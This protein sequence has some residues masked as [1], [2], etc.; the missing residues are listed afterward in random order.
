MADP[1]VNNDSKSDVATYDILVDG[2]VM[3]PSFQLLSLSVMKESNRIPVAKLIFRDGEAAEKEFSLS[4]DAAFV[5]G[6]KIVIKIG[7]DTTNVQ[8]FAGIIIMHAV[9]IKSNGNS[10]LH[11]ECRDEAVR[12][13]V[14]RHSKYYEQL[15][16]AD[17]FNQLLTNYGLTADAEA[18]SLVHKEIVQQ[19][20]TDW[21]FLLLRA[22]ANGMLV[23]INDGTLKISKP[24]TD[25]A[26]V[27]KLTFGST[28]IEFEAEMDARNQWKSVKAASWDYTNQQLFNADSSSTDLSE[29]GNIPG[30]QLAQAINADYEMHHSGHLLQQELQS[31]ADGA[32][33]RSRLAKIKGRAKVEGFSGIKPGD[34]VQLGGVGKRFNG[35]AYVT[36][37]RHDMGEGLWETQIQF[38]LHSEYHVQM[39]KD[40]ADVPSAGLVGP[41]NGLQVGKVVKLESDPDGEDRILIKIPTIDKDAQGIWTRVATLDAGADRGSF[42]LPEIDDEVIVGFVNDD[43]RHAIMLGMLHSSAKAA[44]IVAKDANNEKGFTTRSKMHI[45]FNDDTKTIVIDTPAGNSITIDEQGQK[46][47]IKDQS[48]NKITMATSGITLD[49]PANIDIKAG[50]ILTLSGGASLS[51]GAPSLSIKA[52]AD[53][54]IQGAIAKLSSQGITEV[55]GSIVKIN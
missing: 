55:S 10:E 31:W 39:H 28:I 44:P 15:T 22:E 33:M 23:N 5:P 49:S 54:S 52:D 51:I 6:N 16:D 45:S 14:G 17:L 12:M 41:I 20:I 36:G 32:F 26:P 21:D 47:E 53:V 34:M 13:T 48:Q 27:L 7:R 19:Q 8:V 29:P 38:G 37:I 4:N 30:N 25:A 43:P 3:D 18:T 9:K 2:K 46:I 11:L 42:F 24:K 35:N 50:A 40:I 1:L